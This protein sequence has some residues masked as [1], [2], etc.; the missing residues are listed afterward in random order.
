MSPAWSN[1]KTH[2]K[3]DK[4]FK[5]VPDPHNHTWALVG[6]VGSR[7]FSPTVYFTRLLHGNVNH[8]VPP[9]IYEL[10]TRCEQVNS[11]S[12]RFSIEALVLQY[13]LLAC[14]MET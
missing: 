3:L 11:Y 7:S 12:T 13:I 5:Y 2:Y 14:Y 10:F 9:N 4:F 6:P 8:C 1:S